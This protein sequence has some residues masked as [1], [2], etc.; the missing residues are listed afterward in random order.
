M[1]YVRDW[2]RQESNCRRLEDELR[3]LFRI[4]FAGVKLAWL[5]LIPPAAKRMV[6]GIMPFHI[7]RTH[8]LMTSL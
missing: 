6:I 5:K 2:A 4:A 8:F 3:R 7:P 1:K